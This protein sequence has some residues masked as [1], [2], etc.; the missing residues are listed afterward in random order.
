M[1]ISTNVPKI[2]TFTAGEDVFRTGERVRVQLKGHD[3]WD[4]NGGGYCGMITHIAHDGF[5]VS[6]SGYHS[7]RNIEV[8]FDDVFRMRHI[9]GK[10]NFDTVPFFDRDEEHFWETHIYGRNG[11]EERVEPIRFR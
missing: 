5:K 9:T 1:K 11:I 7:F 10:E 6:V 4:W 8:G 3:G 2:P